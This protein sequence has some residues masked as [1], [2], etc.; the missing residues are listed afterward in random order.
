MT[1]PHAAVPELA[2]LLVGR[3]PSLPL[4]AAALA[5][6][7]DGGG[8][9]AFGDLAVAYREEFLKL[10]AHTRGGALPEAGN[11]S[12]DDARANLG[13]SVLP[14][15]ALTGAVVV[16]AGQLWHDAPVDRKSTRL[17]SSHDQ[18]SYAVFCLEKKKII[19]IAHHENC[20]A[21]H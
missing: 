4:A 14:R 18:I 15:L 19:Q 20:H 6:I 10:W 9:A 7:A 21:Q 17:N 1:D 8:R 12:V 2:E 3:D 5:R 13:S 16:P 11:L